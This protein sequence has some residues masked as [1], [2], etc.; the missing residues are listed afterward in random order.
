[1]RASARERE[2]R[3]GAAVV[4]DEDRR[5]GELDDVERAPIAERQVL[6]GLRF[7]VSI[8]LSVSWLASC[9]DQ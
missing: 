8:E 4:S 9:Q 6:D 5:A 7:E 3:L 2:V 1:L